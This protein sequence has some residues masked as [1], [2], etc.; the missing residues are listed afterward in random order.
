LG[1][2]IE[3]GKEARKETRREKEGTHCSEDEEE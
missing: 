2:E 3:K 1:A